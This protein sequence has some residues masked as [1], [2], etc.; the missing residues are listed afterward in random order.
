MPKNVKFQKKVMGTHNENQRHR[1]IS[2]HITSLLKI[3]KPF[4]VYISITVYDAVTV[5][6]NDV[7]VIQTYWI[8]TDLDRFVKP[9]HGSGKPEKE[10]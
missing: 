3:A 9:K 10:L 1:K 2:N 4:G 7:L 8:P 6:V 5:T